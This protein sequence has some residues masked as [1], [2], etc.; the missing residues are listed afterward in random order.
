MKNRFLFFFAFFLNSCTTFHSLKKNPVTLQTDP[1]I[2]IFAK[3]ICADCYKVDKPQFLIELST[4]SG[5]SQATFKIEGI[6]QNNYHLLRGNVIGLFGEEY[7]SFYIDK[8]TF[9]LDPNK[10]FLSD[11]VELKKI[12]SLFSDLGAKGLRS[13]LCG[14]FAFLKKDPSDGIFAEKNSRKTDEPE[15]E[16]KYFSFST[17]EIFDKKIKVNSQVTLS[18]KGTAYELKTQ[19]VFTEGFFLPTSQFKLYWQGFAYANT[20]TPQKIS[21]FSS[22]HEQY[23]IHVLDYN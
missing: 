21:F 11:Q 22:G 2:L 12:F 6:W 5:T 3:S 1:A 10:K 13:L 18:P 4:S 8:N 14:E 15:I 17:L 20:V 7:L 19:S 23:T 9:F 16:K